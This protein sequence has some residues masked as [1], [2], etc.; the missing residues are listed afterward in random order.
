MHCV[1][2]AIEK[3][4]CDWFAEGEKMDAEHM[5]KCLE[6][7]CDVSGEIHYSILPQPN[8]SR[9]PSHCATQYHIK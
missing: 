4:I 9:R 7:Y 6:A 2:L 5:V 8:T 1:F 3:R